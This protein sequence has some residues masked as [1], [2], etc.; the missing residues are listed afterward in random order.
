MTPAR[1]ERA[2]RLERIKDTL[3]TC[4]ERATDDLAQQVAPRFTPDTP[5][6]TALMREAAQRFAFWSIC[7]QLACFRARRCRRKPGEC[8]AACAPLVPPDVRNSVMEQMKEAV[9]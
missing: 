8:F 2:A 1:A 9:R 7:G 5:L 4:L 6:R 3:I